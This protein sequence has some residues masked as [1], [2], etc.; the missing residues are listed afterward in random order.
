M[1]KMLMCIDNRY[2]KR[3]QFPDGCT[4]IGLADARIAE[5]SSLGA[6]NE[7]AADDSL[8][9][10]RINSW[11]RIFNIISQIKNLRIKN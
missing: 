1:V 2:G 6:K 4:D 5:Q 9:I 7:P 11:K 10:D 8:L 3:S